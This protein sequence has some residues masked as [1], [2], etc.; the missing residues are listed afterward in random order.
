MN[1]PDCKVAYHN[2]TLDPTSSGIGLTLA[3]PVV[4]IPKSKE[5]NVE[6]GKEGEAATAT[7]LQ[8]RL[9]SNNS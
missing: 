2:I 1:E 4:F 9:P 6:E 5:V 7:A 3:T 8:G